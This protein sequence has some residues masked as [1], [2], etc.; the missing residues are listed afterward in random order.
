MKT[1]TFLEIQKK[2]FNAFE[3]GNFAE[4]QKLIDETVIRFPDRM[5]KYSF[6]R[7]CT[8]A[9]IGEKEEAISV[10]QEALSLGVWWNPNT[11]MR[12][13]DLSLLHDE[14]Q[15]QL[16]IQQCQSILEKQEPKE[17]LFVPFGDEHAQ[18]G[19]FS[20]HWRGSNIEDFAPFWVE[21]ND[22]L[23][24]F[25]QSSQP[26]AF[27]SYCW[28]DHE[29]AIVEVRHALKRFNERFEFDN[30]IVAGASQ[31]GKLA[32]ELALDNKS[33][34]VK[35]FIAVVPAIVNLTEIESMIMKANKPNLKGCI[36]TGDQD[37]FYKKT[38]ELV[39]IFKQN[40]I[41]CNIFVTEGLGHF[42]PDDF[43][44]LLIKAVDFINKGGLN[45][46]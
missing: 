18:T 34:H 40:N 25:P 33:L 23:I 46:D 38:Q 11:L 15:Y 26:Y 1:K 14:D 42:F 3:S 43:S 16:I 37:P 41:E 24:G 28:D 45:E 30:L 4:V 17:N 32:I 19:I 5:E 35:G 7:A 20:I 12:D 2:L 22:Y 36:I 13:P 39:E 8:F 21:G 31:G 44:K 29:K 6:W 9:R 27:N 10:L